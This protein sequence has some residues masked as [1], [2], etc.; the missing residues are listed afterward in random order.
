MSATLLASERLQQ[1]TSRFASCR[2]AVLG[3]FFLDRYLDIDPALEEPSVETGKP[4]HQVAAVRCYPGAAGTVVSNLSALQT[5][6]LHAIGFTGDDGEGFE[7][8]YGLAKLG[9]K[10][11][12]LH[13]TTQRFTPTYLKP[14]DMT[15]PGLEGEHS[16]IDTKNRLPTP[17]DIQRAIGD[18]LAAV[19]DGVDGV[20]VLDQV[21]ARDC[22]VVTDAVRDRIAELAVKHPK[23]FFLADSRRRIREFRNVMIKPNEFEAV[24]NEDP[25]PGDTV[26]FDELRSTASQL[27][28]STAAPVFITR[29]EDGIFVSEPHW[30]AVPGV[31]LTGEIDSTGAGDSVT[32]GCILALSAGG[33]CVEAAVIGNL[34]A[35][36]TVE[37][38]ATT[39]TAQP[40]ELAARLEL[41]HEQNDG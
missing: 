21:E 13:S 6:E 25:Q 31:R 30:T 9:C 8:R 10:T 17:P 38:L 41:L 14:R 11:E 22:G 26:G 29:G 27:Q 34:V 37:Q 4:A 5:G 36:I 18:S 20:V 23:V 28:A 7:L 3:D 1:I 40:D 2:I 35:S 24:G 19:I 32:A 15:T 12:H 16:R 39:G 33:S